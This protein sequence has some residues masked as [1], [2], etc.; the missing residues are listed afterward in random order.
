LDGHSCVFKPEIMDMVG[1]QMAMQ[2]Y[3]EAVSV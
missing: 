3:P 2:L 1:P